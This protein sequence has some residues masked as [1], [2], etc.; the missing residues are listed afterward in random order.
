M[1]SDRASLRGRLPVDACIIR[2][3]SQFQSAA[4]FPPAITLLMSPRNWLPGIGLSMLWLVNLLPYRVKIQ[5]GMA[6]GGLLHSVLRSRR[7]IAATNL[8]LCFPELSQRERDDILRRAFRHLGAGLI[9][10][11]MSWWTAPAKIQAITEVEGLSHLRDAAAAGNGIIMIGAHFSCL[12][13]GAK[14][15]NPYQPFHVVQRR[16][17]NPMFNYVMQKGRAAATLSVVDNREVRKIVKIVRDGGAVWLAPDHDMGEKGSVYAPFFAQ[18]AA[19][20]TAPAKFVR[21]TGAA[22]IFCATHRNA[23]NTGY[24]LRISPIPARIATLDDEAAAALLNQT[25]ADNIRHDV[26]QYYWFHR[27]FKSQ[28]GKSKGALYES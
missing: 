18:P 9:E 21:L 4:M 2:P 27:R 7:R 28:P 11:A 5:L 16:Q 19:T 25:I 15:I 24:H 8:Q 6:L 10:T 23:D 26:A 1:L 17:K 13:I 14:M 20:I 12:D 3:V 22:A